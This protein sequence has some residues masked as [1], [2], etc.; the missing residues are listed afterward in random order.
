MQINAKQLA[1]LNKIGQLKR[2]STRK[3]LANKLSQIDVKRLQLRQ[4]F[5]ELSK[6]DFSKGVCSVTDLKLQANN[7]ESRS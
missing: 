7:L 6:L 2:S 1:V 5:A 3:L 4:L